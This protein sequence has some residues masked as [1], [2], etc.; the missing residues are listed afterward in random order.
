[1]DLGNALLQF[2]G[3]VWHEPELGHVP[4]GMPATVIVT[5][6]S[7]EIGQEEKDEDCDHQDDIFNEGLLLMS[8]AYLLRPS[9]SQSF[10]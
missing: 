1:M 8:F 9:W 5:Q 4:V 6:F 3:L 2:F 10:I 7:C